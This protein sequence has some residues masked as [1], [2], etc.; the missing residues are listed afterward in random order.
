MVVLARF[1]C[2]SISS[3]SRRALYRSCN[4]RLR[5]PH[6]NL[7]TWSA[8]PKDQ[9]TDAL[10]T[11]EKPSPRTCVHVW[12]R[13]SLLKIESIQVH[14]ETNNYCKEVPQLFNRGPQLRFTR[15][16][17]NTRQTRSLQHNCDNNAWALTY[18]QLQRLSHKSS[19]TEEETLI[20]YNTQHAHL[21]TS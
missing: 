8:Y 7:T 9:L 4:S 18:V 6:F 3:W 10:T 14:M 2:S 16:F 12:I 17:N 11:I 15:L 19:V 21:H 5:S 1:H 13:Y 20:Q